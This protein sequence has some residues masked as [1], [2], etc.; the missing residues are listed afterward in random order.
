MNQNILILGGT[1]AMGEP[2]ATMLAKAG[3]RITV[4]S[5]Q[6]R[7]SVQNI[8]YAK[9]DA[10]DLNFLGGLFAEQTWDAIVDFMVYNTAEFMQRV[11]MFLMNTK[12]YIFISSARVYARSDSP[13]TEDTPRLLDVCQDAEYL[14]TDEYALAKARQENILFHSGHQNWTIIRPSITYNINR[15]QLGVLEKENWLYRALRGR[16]IVFSDDIADKVTTMT[17]GSDVAKGIAAVIG[18]DAAKGQVFHVTEKHS[19]QWREV[20][21]EYLAVLEKRTGVRPRVVMTKKSTCFQ[22]P[23]KKYQIMYCRYYNRSFDNRKITKFIDTQS[24]ENAMTGLQ[25]CLDEFLEEKKFKNIDWRMEALHDLAAGE[26]TPLTEIFGIKNKIKY[27]LY[28]HHLGAVWEK[29][30]KLKSRHSGK[31]SNIF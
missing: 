30:E 4:T 29:G 20:L 11:E 6:D 28:R 22:L 12:Q 5:R 7:L 1:G 14:R 10:H 13:I 19:Y 31:N 3:M 25:R 17:S 24:F 23:G 2:L 18:R 27:M 21:S 16:S 15:L 8:I 9:G 26:R